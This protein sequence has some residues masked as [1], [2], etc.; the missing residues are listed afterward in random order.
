MA[1]PSSA[2][3]CPAAPI[4]SVAKLG[5]VRGWAAGGGGSGGAA[6]GGGGSGGA[7]ARRGGFRGFGASWEE[8]EG[9]GEEEVSRGTGG[10]VAMWGNWD[11]MVV[12]VM[13]SLHNG[14]LGFRP[15]SVS[16]V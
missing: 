4:P 13:A 10:L 7:A 11:W 16:L 14:P 2:A 3:S 5:M 8:G 12:E 15:S 9:G 1:R 6:A